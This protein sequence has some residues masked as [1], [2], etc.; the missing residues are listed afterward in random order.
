MMR[1]RT[2]A[3][4]GQEFFFLSLRLPSA[5]FSLLLRSSSCS[6]FLFFLSLSGPLKC[7]LELLPEDEDEVEGDQCSDRATFFSFLLLLFS[8]LHSS[9]SS[10]LV[11]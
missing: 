8:F 1:L 4:I 6:L 2:V 7:P 5:F 9:S 3:L 10:F 11:F